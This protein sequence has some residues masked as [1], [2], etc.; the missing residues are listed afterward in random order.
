MVV[1]WTRVVVVRVVKSG[2]I[3]RYILKGE[4]IRFADGLIEWSYEKNIQVKNDSKI[5]SL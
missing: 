2:W 4:Q 3:W 1:A 5:F